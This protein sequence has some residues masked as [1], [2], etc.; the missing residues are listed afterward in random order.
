MGE[1]LVGWK[2]TSDDHHGDGDHGDADDGDGVG[3]GGDHGECD[4][5]D[6]GGKDDIDYHGHGYDSDNE[7]FKFFSGDFFSDRSHQK[8]CSN[9][10]ERAADQQSLTSIQVEAQII[11]RFRSSPDLH[12][13]FIRSSSDLHQIFT[14]SS[15]P[16]RSSMISRPFQI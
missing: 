12:Q 15:S 1:A 5:E 3:D 9:D 13:I 16:T 4:D 7:R 14:R 6:D 8:S 10:G 2:N 11:I